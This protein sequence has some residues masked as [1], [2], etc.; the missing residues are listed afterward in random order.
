[1]NFFSFTLLAD[2]SSDKTLMHHLTWLLKQNGVEQ[3]V[4]SN[5]AD[6]SRL[7]EKPNGLAEKIERSV[8]LYPCDLLFIHRDAEREPPENRRTEIAE[9]L[10]NLNENLT[11]PSFVCVIP[12]RM[13]EAW[14]LF[15]EDAIRRAAGNSD[16]KARMNLP[17][18]KNTENIPDPKEVL[19]NAIR[20]ASEKSG[21]KLKELNKDMSNLRYRVS[22]LM[23]DFSPLRNLRAFQHLEADIK[24]L[25][26]EYENQ[27]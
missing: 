10:L 11:K 16:G 12:V 17:K 27:K 22:E 6:L 8:E 15:D 1:M 21:R 18:L 25:I 19:F 24:N 9:A 5:W 26:A 14:L 13:S 23:E 7:R 4:V 2:G 20:T 3:P